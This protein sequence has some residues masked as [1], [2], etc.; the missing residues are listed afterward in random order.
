MCPWRE[1]EQENNKSLA[2]SE[3]AGGRGRSILWCS[4]LGRSFPS[5]KQ[6]QTM[7]TV[8]MS[9]WKLGKWLCHFLA[10]RGTD[11]R[12]RLNGDMKVNT[13]LRDG[14]N[15]V[16]GHEWTAAFNVSLTLSVLL[17]L[18]PAFSLGVQWSSVSLATHQGFSLVK[19]SNLKSP[20]Q[21]P[22]IQGVLTSSNHL[23]CPSN[24][25]KT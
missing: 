15:R 16:A 22:T 25:S 7:A 21:F 9:V 18:S 5:P 19:L 6:S 17:S 12:T 23:F 2:E 1:K 11:G 14:G 4:W 24:S 8:F 3:L 20:S 13:R 10:L